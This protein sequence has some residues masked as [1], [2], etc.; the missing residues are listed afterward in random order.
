MPLQNDR[1]KKTALR[2]AKLLGALVFWCLAGCE[3]G[4]NY[5]TPGTKMPASF[6]SGP[7]PQ[8]ANW[9]GTDQSS[10]PAIDAAK[11]WRGLHDQELNSLVAR[12]I[13]NNF[14]IENCP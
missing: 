12:A 11:W 13:Q 5:R 6:T 9:N 10:K 14:N 1:R 4:P 8:K 2:K 7:P 3:V